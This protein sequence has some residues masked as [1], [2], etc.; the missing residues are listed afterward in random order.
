MEIRALETNKCTQTTA[1]YLLLAE[2]IL[3]EKQ[4][5]EIQIS[6]ASPR[7]SKAQLSWPAVRNTS[8]VLQRIPQG[9]EIFLPEENYT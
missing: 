3:R 7:N 8:R 5:K 1:T 6:S 4:D 9:P 2:R